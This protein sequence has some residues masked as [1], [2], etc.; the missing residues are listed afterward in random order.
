MGSRRPCGEGSSQHLALNPL[1]TQLSSLFHGET[2]KT[3]SHPFPFIGSAL[4]MVKGK[5]KEYLDF[6]VGEIH[7]GACG[8]NKYLPPKLPFWLQDNTAT[9]RSMTSSGRCHT[10]P[11]LEA[12][13]EWWVPSDTHAL[14]PPTHPQS[15]GCSL[16]LLPPPS[17]HTFSLC[18]SGYRLP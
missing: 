6:R 5:V 14:H 7:C 10:C 8:I 18:R 4:C 2:L 1:N 17:T 15:T 3:S 12:D 16:C 9:G 11:D 13:R